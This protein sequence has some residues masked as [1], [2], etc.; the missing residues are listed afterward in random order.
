METGESELAALERELR[1]ELGVEI[2]TESTSH[3]CRVTVG[4]VEDPVHLSAWL[5]R[6]W[7][8]TP[9]NAAP[10]EHD[11]IGWFGLEELPPLAHVDVRAAVVDA[12]SSRPT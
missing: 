7:S 3:L 8:G 6:E 1:E 9:A 4:P 10:D 12:M 2:V 11:E 5:V